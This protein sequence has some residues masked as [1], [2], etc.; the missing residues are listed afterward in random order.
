MVK[1]Q[2]LLNS[3]FLFNFVNIL[4]NRI[5]FIA[6]FIFPMISPPMFTLQ[7]HSSFLFLPNSLLLAFMLTLSLHAYYHF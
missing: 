4:F 2:I 5:F 1:S 3:Q 6:A 7:I